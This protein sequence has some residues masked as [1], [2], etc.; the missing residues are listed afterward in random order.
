MPINAGY[1]VLNKAVLDYIDGDTTSFEREPMER[2]VR[3]GQLM[4][5]QHNGFWQCMDTKFQKDKLEEMIAK[6]RAPWMV[7]EQ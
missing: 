3:E 6:N 1:M 4:S 5:Y 7:W 2:L